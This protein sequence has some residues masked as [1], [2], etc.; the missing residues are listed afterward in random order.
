MKKNNIKQTPEQ[1]SDQ[2]GLGLDYVKRVLKVKEGIELGDTQL[3]AIATK[4]SIDYV[5]RVLAFKR[6]SSDILTALETIQENRKQLI[7]DMPVGKY[8]K[9]DQ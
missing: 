6:T 2:T 5:Q 8:K 1:I 7:A 9:I 4:W 3:T